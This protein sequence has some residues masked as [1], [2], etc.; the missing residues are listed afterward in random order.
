MAAITAGVIAGVG[1]VGAVANSINSADAAQD[2][3]RVQTKAANTAAE[4][5]DRRFDLFRDDLATYRQAGESAMPL[6][7]EFNSNPQAQYDYLQSNPLFQASMDVSDRD[8]AARLASQ[9]RVGT[10]D[11]SEQLQQNYLLN[12][13]PLIQQREQQLLNLAQ[14]GQASSA[15]TGAAGI[16]AATTSGDLITQ[17]ANSSAAGIIGQENARNQG[18]TDAIGGASTIAG[19]WGK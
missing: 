9:G 2:A 10:G 18:I 1:T 11:A 5:V 19:I 14:I 6:L 16:N 3:A 7:S 15:Q 8:T 4:G 17:G 13:A 12:A